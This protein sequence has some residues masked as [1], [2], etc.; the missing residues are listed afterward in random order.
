MPLFGE[1][2]AALKKTI[3]RPVTN[4]LKTPLWGST[5]LFLF[6]YVMWAPCPLF[7]GIDLITKDRCPLPSDC[8]PHSWFLLVRIR[9]T[10]TLVQKFTIEL[11]CFKWINASLSESSPIWSKSLVLIYICSLAPARCK[12]NAWRT[13]SFSLGSH[14][15]WVCMAW[16]A[17][18]SLGPSWRLAWHKEV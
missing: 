15:G 11:I 1:L 16:F 12:L 9:I 3:L 10:A 7:T 6:A 18:A 8:F 2:S 5:F 17:V 13:I 14:V 4:N